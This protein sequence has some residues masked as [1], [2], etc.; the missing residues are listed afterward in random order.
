MSS[1]FMPDGTLIALNSLELTADIH[2][3][4]PTYLETV[5]KYHNPGELSD[6]VNLFQFARRTKLSYFE[7]LEE[8]PEYRAH[9]DKAMDDV[10]AWFC[11]G[12]PMGLAA[13]YPF[14]EELGYGTVDDDVVLVDVGGCRGQLLVDV[15]K[16]LP[17]LTG[18]LVLEDL[19]KTVSGF[20]APLGI[21]VVPYNFFEPQP[22]VGKRSLLMSEEPSGVA[23]AL[24]EHAPMSS[25]TSCT[26]GPITSARRS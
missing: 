14:E 26:T 17:N 20:E 23:K 16:H 6:T 2:P 25:V 15:H 18:R 13:L 8:H 1:P 24:Q 5:A 7:W 12:E 10:N 4:M 9:F 21:E 22:I 3:K 19:P 11:S